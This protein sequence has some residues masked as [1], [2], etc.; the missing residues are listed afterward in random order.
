[1]GNTG[2]AVD[3]QG[4]LYVG[5]KFGIFERF[6][7]PVAF[8]STGEPLV[9]RLDGEETRGLAVDFSSDDAYVDH[10]TSIAAYG[11]S[12]NPV[13]RFGSPQ[14]QAS[15]GV[16]VSSATGTV[17]A[18]DTATGEVDVFTSFVVPDVTTGAASAFTE[19]S[20]TVAGV[21]N[22]DGLPVT[23]CVLEYGTSES[24]GQSE[25]CSP[26]PGSGSG[27]VAVSAQLK[28]LEPLTSI[29]SV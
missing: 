20:V 18:S 29:T 16:A 13:E 6:S 5:E 21:V 4:V 14:L 3:S 26:A 23:S 10:E 15:E 19:T 7:F 27:P 17:Y 22:P 24:Y 12:H 28:G 25:P 11:P 9:Q 8:S 2:F 1:M